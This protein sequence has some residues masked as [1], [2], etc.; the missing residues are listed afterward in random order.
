MS[1]ERRDECVGGPAV[2]GPLCPQCVPPESDEEIRAAIAGPELERPGVFAIVRD[3]AVTIARASLAL[4]PEVLEQAI[5]EGERVSVGAIVDATIAGG[6]ELE[7]HLALIRATL[8]YR[9]ALE[10]LRHPATS[11]P[12]ANR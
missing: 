2:E 7:R 9:Q 10:A 5:A 4:E 12:G 11:T 3:L 1:D 6:A 8:T